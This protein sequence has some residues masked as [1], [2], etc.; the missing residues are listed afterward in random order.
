MIRVDRITSMTMV[1]TYQRK[2]EELE[3]S[4]KSRT[5]KLKGNPDVRVTVEAETFDG[6]A[7]VQIQV[8][9]RVIIC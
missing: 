8:C 5:A 6:P 3:F 4:E 9:G 7:K 1:V 2:W